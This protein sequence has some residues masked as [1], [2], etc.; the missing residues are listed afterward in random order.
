MFKIIFPYRWSTF[1]GIYFPQVFFHCTKLPLEFLSRLQLKPLF[2]FLLEGSE[3][4]HWA[5]SF[6]LLLCSIQFKFRLGR[7]EG[8]GENK[9]ESPLVSTVINYLHLYLHYSCLYITF[10][11]SP[12]LSLSPLRTQLIHSWSL[13]SDPLQGK[14]KLRNT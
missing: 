6:I 10:P 5:Q 13:H 7:G 8:W 14:F 9:S 11:F 3:S 4:P 12:S 2:H 1:F